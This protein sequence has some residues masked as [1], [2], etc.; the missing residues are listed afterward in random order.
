MKSD[1][2]KSDQVK[3][4]QNKSNQIETAKDNPLFFEI[5][6]TEAETKEWLTELLKTK[7]KCDVAAVSIRISSERLIVGVL[8][9]GVK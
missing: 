7:R 3:T 1:E 6:L 9:N 8:P 4:N 2:T 5:P